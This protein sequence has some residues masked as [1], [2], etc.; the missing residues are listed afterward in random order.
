MNAK[1]KQ[2]NLP[3]RPHLR[4][5]NRYWNSG[6]KL[7]AGIDE[8]GRGA[9]A[10]PVVAAAVV[11]PMRPRFLNRKL[12]DVRDS[13]CLSPNIRD[14]MSRL[15]FDVALFSGFGSSSPEEVD[16]CGIVNATRIAMFRAVTALS[17]QPDQLLIDAVDLNN[18]LDIPQ[19]AMN[20][21]DSI[22]LSIAAASILAKVYRDRLMVALSS[23]Y[24]GYGF[25]RHKGYGTNM[26]YDMLTQLR[27]TPVHR[28][29]FKPIASLSEA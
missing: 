28:H 23:E 1:F 21:G 11:L 18:E 19:K 25:E 15:I 22:S 8:V 27:A 10:G 13:K 14:K 2:A 20:F 3:K 4:L 12:K 17:S 7:V 9:W 5:E 16:G 6:Y 26:H 24:P 29:T